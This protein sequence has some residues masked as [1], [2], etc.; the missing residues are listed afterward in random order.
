MATPAYNQI[1]EAMRRMQPM[2][3]IYDGQERRFCP[4]ILGHNKGQEKALVYQV[5]GRT[6]EGPLI[7]PTWKCFFVSKIQALEICDGEWRAGERHRTKQTCVD[8]VDLDVNPSSPYEPKRK[9]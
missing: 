9:V 4:I 5:G 7:R 8:G 1:A 3:C 6:S 2:T